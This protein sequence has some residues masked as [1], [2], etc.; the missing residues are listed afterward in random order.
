[1]IDVEKMTIKALYRGILKGL[2]TYPSIKRDEMRE[3]VKLDFREGKLLKNELEI[4]KAIRKARMGFSHIL[5]YQIKMEEINGPSPRIEKE[6][7]LRSFALAK[8]DPEFVYF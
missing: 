3:A 7:N 1:M 8:S 5:M 6:V 4:K 2:K